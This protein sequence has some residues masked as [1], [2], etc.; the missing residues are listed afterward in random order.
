M[1][2]ERFYAA[3]LAL[4]PGEFRDT[5]GADVL[6]A[7]RELHR[8]N[9]RPPLAFW[10]FALAD[11]ARSVCHEQIDACRTGT[12]SFVLRWLAVCALGIFGTGLVAS[13]VTRGFAYFYHPYLE[14]WQFSPWSYGALLG[15]G[16]G[17]TQ[18]VTLRHGVRSSLVWVVASA[19]SASLGL[20]LAATLAWT[21]GPIGCGIAI[22]AFVGGCQWTLARARHRRPA[23]PLLASTI[24]VAAAVVLFDGLMRRAL[25]GMNPVAADFS[26]PG[27]PR[28]QY[29]D[30]INVLVRG[31]QQPRNWADVAFEFAA[32]VISGLTIG[33]MTARQLFEGRRAD[34]AGR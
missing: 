12:R 15:A 34:Q 13:L 18:T 8:A 22:G 29:S 32:M 23:W 4:Y 2:P 27:F 11:L 16:L 10:R 17:V 28:A 19:A 30:A 14:G 26:A 3:L 25:G 9:R 5:Y 20:H 31:L 6:A 33:A 24:S 21:A 7:F 1:T